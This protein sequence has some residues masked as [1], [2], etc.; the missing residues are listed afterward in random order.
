MKFAHSL[1]AGAALAV[2]MSSTAI[3]ADLLT[4]GRSDL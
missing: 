3:A 1:L 4:P 2:S